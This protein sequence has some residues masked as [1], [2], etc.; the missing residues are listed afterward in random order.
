MIDRA[1]P[2]PKKS[3]KRFWSRAVLAVLPAAFLFA[4]AAAQAPS[5]TM[6]GELQAGEWEL[7]FRD[8]AP[9]RKICLR[10]GRELIQLRHPGRECTQYVV[11]NTATHST[12]QYTCPGNGYGLTSI[13]KETASLVQIKSSGIAGT[14]AFDFAAEARRVGSCR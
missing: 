1:I 8:G 2:M 10:T 4:P 14:R 9:T 6:L 12:V 3:S 5:L 11:D 7:R 13:R